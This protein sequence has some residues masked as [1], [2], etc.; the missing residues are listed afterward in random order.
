M[1]SFMYYDLIHHLRR[2]YE[3][4]YVEPTSIVVLRMNWK[5]PLP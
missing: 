5:C 4:G 2:S 3:L 1:R